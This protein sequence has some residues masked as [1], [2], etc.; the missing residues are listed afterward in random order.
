MY[1]HVNFLT[2][3]KN[4]YKTLLDSQRLVWNTASPCL[5]WKSKIAR[6]PNDLNINPAPMAHLRNFR[7]IRR[8]HVYI[9]CWIVTSLW[10]DI[11]EYHYLPEKQQLPETYLFLLMVE[12]NLFFLAQMFPEIP[13]M[14][15]REWQR[16]ETPI[17]NLCCLCFCVGVWAEHCWLSVRCTGHSVSD[18][19]W[20]QVCRRL[21]LAEIHSTGPQPAAV[22]RLQ[23]NAEDALS[24]I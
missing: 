8:H 18:T 7:R 16:E 13:L 19:L 24:I 20:L 21:S 5:T 17:I 1:T 11:S 9:W 2:L 6:K 10:E 3:L 22:S 12:S 23:T 4:V 14:G 15:E